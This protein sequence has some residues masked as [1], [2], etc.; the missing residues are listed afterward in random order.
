MAVVSWNSVQI[1]VAPSFYLSGSLDTSSG[2]L[3]FNVPATTGT[4][5][6][7]MKISIGF[8]TEGN[9][10]FNNTLLLA[11][12]SAS[13]CSYSG[14]VKS[15]F[16]GSNR[17]ALY[18]WCST[19]EDNE[20]DAHC[21]ISH[22]ADVYPGYNVTGTF[23]ISDPANLTAIYNDNKYNNNAGISAAETS[24]RVDV[25]T[26]N[27]LEEVAY[28]LNGGSWIY[29]SPQ[30]EYGLG[31]KQNI[32]GL[33]AGTSYAIVFSGKKRGGDWNPSSNY[34]KI[35]IRTLHAKPSITTSVKTRG[36][37]S[38]IISW[39]SDKNIK[40]IQYSLDGG[41]WKN[42]QTGQNK[43]SGDYTVS[44]LSPNTKYTIKTRLISTDTYD[45]RTSNESSQTPTTYDIAKITSSADL[46][47]G[48]ILHITKTNPSGVSND[49]KIEIPLST[50]VVIGTY[51]ASSN[52]FNITF[53][54]DEWDKMY[55][56]YTNEN[57]VPFKITVI[58][59]GTKDYTSSKSG[60]LTL[61]GN[62]KTARVGV[63][64]VPRRA[65]CWVGVGGSAKRAVVWVGVDGKGRRSI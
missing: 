1:H 15:Y 53:T 21:D 5:G 8:W 2:A 55:R 10:N 46:I 49:V 43:K 3:S 45:A 57:T 29:T 28:T 36:L 7:T 52:D 24:I 65:K 13:G 47:F 31:Y 33:K 17:A 9:S 4:Y 39:T 35:T 50:S 51:S 56:T 62:A 44:G 58:T 25:R 59:H 60:T 54:D 27:Y 12:G 37:E 20:G 34:Q 19:H 38:V 40:T 61:T 11:T 26:S 16:A 64:N 22:A 42:A 32:T 30:G 48:D 18:M 23:N 14:N 6:Y 41:A 63:S